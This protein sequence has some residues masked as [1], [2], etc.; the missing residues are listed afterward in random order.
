MRLMIAGMAVVGATALV[1]ACPPADAKSGRQDISDTMVVNAPKEFVWSA[2]T[3][4]D[5]FD[6]NVHSTDGDEAVVAQK[7]EKIPFYG[8]VDT[9]LKIKVKE[10]EY[11][12]Y[13]LIKCDKSLKQMS[14]SWQLTPI[15]KLRTQVKLT[16]S[17]EPG[18]PIPRFL[19][20]KF[21]KMKVHGRLDK[22]RQLA[23][24]L[25]E[26]KKKSEISQKDGEGT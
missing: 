14:G 3:A 13:D 19:V 22:T 5:K 26:K 11:L 6:V 7:F 25:Y 24:H 8:T 10:N 20:N 9:T 17:V 21:I 18:L 23:E 16:S 12:G 15:D 1:S 2:V 4:A